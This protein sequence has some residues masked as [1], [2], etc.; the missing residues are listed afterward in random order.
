MAYLNVE[1]VEEALLTLS[2]TYDDISYIIELPN[3]RIEGRT[4]HALI[5]G[6]N[7]ENRKHKAILFTGSVHAREWG[8]SDICVYFVADLLEAHTNGTGLRYKNQYFESYEI[9]RIIEDINIII[10]PDVNPD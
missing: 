5:L 6:K 4:I 2:T 10:V 8:G 7:M 1:E 3:K 9:K